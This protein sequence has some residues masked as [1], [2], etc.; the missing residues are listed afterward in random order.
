MHAIVNRNV[1]SISGGSASVEITGPGC[2]VRHHVTLK[3]TTGTSTKP[4][5][6]TTAANRAAWR[7]GAARRRTSR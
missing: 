3:Y 4:K 1:N 7:P 6:P 2:T 5:I